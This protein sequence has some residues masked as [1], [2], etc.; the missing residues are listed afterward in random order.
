VRAFSTSQT[1]K[2]VTE[3]WTEDRIRNAQPSPLTVQPD[4]PPA[5]EL[6][7]PK[8][9]KPINLLDP[10]NVA[11]PERKRGAKILAR[12]AAPADANSAPASPNGKLF[13]SVGG[14][15]YVCSAAAVDASV[16]LTAAHCAYDRSAKAQ[17]TN[18]LFI[19]QFTPTSHGKQY[20]IT[21]IIVPGDWITS[22]YKYSDQA[23]MRVSGSITSVYGILLRPTPQVV[24]PGIEFGYPAQPPFS[25]T[26]LYS[27]DPVE[28]QNADPSDK[29]TIAI[30]SNMTPGSSGGPWVGRG[31]N[32]KWGYIFGLNSYKFTTN[33]TR[34][35]SP[36]FW[37][38]M[39]DLVN[40]ANNPN[41]K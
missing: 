22:G 35:Y 17:V 3:Y 14:A 11:S 34:M 9:L 21:Q 28:A 8:S 12:Q 27:V 38:I 37:F 18:A 33:S 2:E 31:A 25:G 1:S 7:R 16:I 6:S 41:C 36:Y 19:W 4:H 32:G 23:L 15:D 10:K 13:F 20:F 5:K 26:Q 30:Y 39:R 29:L 24:A 40:C